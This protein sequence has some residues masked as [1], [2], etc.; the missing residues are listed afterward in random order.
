MKLAS[1]LAILIALL[2]AMV[3]G[4]MHMT[5]EGCFRDDPEPRPAGCKPGDKECTVDAPADPKPPLGGP[6]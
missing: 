3:L 6:S 1:K 4:W 5:K 2:I